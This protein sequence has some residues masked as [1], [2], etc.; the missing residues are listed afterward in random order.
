MKKIIIYI[1]ILTGCSNYK[2][3]NSNN[4][5][6]ERNRLKTGDILIKEKL[7]KNPTSWMGHSSIMINNYRV[8][9]FPMIGE[10]FYSTNV[11]NWLNE[12]GR[13]VIVLRYPRFNE[14]F[15]KQFIKNIKKYSHGKYKITFLKK[16]DEGFYCSR[17]VWFLYYKTAKDLGYNLD[18]DSDGGIFVFP[19]D[20]IKSKE[21]VQIYF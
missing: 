7:L 11:Y 10:N 15:E 1:L 5:I 13:R 20:F 9:D 21:L 14:K 2:W 6:E 4:I 8:G 16:S 19:Y 17:Y 12:N 18:L 3:S